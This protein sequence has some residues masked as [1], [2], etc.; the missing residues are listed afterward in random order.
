MTGASGSDG[1]IFLYSGG[2]L[3]QKHPL[4]LNFPTNP[5][6]GPML[7]SQSSLRSKLP[8]VFLAAVLLLGAAAPELFAQDEGTA[9]EPGKEER[10][11]TGRVVAF[12]LARASR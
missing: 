5:T 3:N 4:P 7:V 11:G 1:A 12:V 8:W 2:V 10:D 9:E 6:S